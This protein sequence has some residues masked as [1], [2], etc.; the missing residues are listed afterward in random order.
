MRRLSK[1]RSISFRIRIIFGLP[2]ARQRAG[3]ENGQAKQDQSGWKPT[4][5]VYN[6]GFHSA[7][8][9]PLTCD[10]TKEETRALVTARQSRQD[11]GQI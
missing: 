4:L 2:A 8:Q 7:T 10:G 5:F 3:G 1:H 6:I 9:T 11:P